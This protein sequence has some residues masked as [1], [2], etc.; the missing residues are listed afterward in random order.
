MILHPD[1]SRTEACEAMRCPTRAQRIECC[2]ERYCPL[3]WMRASEED[4]ARREER[5]RRDDVKEKDP[6][7]GGKSLE[8]KGKNRSASDVR[9]DADPVAP[10]IPGSSWHKGEV[11]K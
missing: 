11:K 7:V 9:D 6:R 3:A 4:R 1:Y 2:R 5:E 8:G 10:G